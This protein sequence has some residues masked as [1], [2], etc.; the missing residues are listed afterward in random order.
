MTANRKTPVRAAQKAKHRPTDPAPSPWAGL[1]RRDGFYDDPDQRDL[2]SR[3]LTYI[4]AGV[5][6]HLSGPAGLGKTTLALRIAEDLGRP[7]AFMTGN[8][9]L[10]ASD[11]TGRE[12][13]QTTRTVVDTYI[14][15]VRRTDAE[16]RAD[17]KNSILAEAMRRG[18][19]LVYDEF[20]RASSEANA[21][22]LS[23]L[24]EGVLITAD[25]AAQFTRLEAHPD[26]R[27][28]LTSNPHDY[29]G[30][31]GA[32]DALMDRVLTLPL[33]E[34]SIQQLIGIVCTRT[35]LDADT[36]GRI[37]S[38]VDATPAVQDPRHG[39]RLRAALMIAR[40]AAHLRRNK[41]LDTD[42]LS[43]ISRDVLLGRSQSGAAVTTLARANAVGAQPVGVRTR[44]VA[45]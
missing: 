12:V 7:V 43:E 10:N 1:S 30:V 11:F 22:L 5:C 9:W 28:V 31:N 21:M 3:A 38:L 14:Q 23:V 20:T 36:A 2:I 18:H 33:P 4:E 35:G 42:K 24:E 16:S 39:S 13:G 34:P 29:V 41:Q 45:T 44:K 32:P 6:L 25:R 27:V 19:T 17:W 40:I 8:Q 37:V 26:F 15:S